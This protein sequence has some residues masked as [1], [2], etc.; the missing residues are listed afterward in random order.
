M[1]DDGSQE[2]AQFM[3]SEEG[4]VFAVN[5]T[6]YQWNYCFNKAVDHTHKT[7]SITI[8]EQ[9]IMKNCMEKYASGAIASNHGVTAYREFKD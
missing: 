9:D 1:N 8:A 5:A 7:Q 3:N 2:Y 6:S 4:M